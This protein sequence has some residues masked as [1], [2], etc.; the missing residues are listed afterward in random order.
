MARLRYGLG[1]LA[2][3]VCGAAQAADLMALFGEAER[4]DPTY[5]AVKS[6]LEATRELKPQARA[7]AFLPKV[8]IQAE[9][10][11]EFQEITPAADGGGASFGGGEFEFLS[12]GYTLNVTQ[13]VYH[14]DR[15]AQLKQAD[16]RIRASELELDAALQD[17]IVR[18]SERYF[19]VLAAA[20]S[21]EFAQAEKNALARQLE[22]TRERF[23]V[24]LLPITDVEEAQA[25]HDLAVA[26]EIEADNLLDNAH[27]ALR[28]IVGRYHTEFSRLREGIPLLRPAPADIEVWSRKAQEQNLALGRARAEAETARQEIQR[29]TSGHYPTL[30]VVGRHGFNTTGGRFGNVE[31]DASAIG[32]QLTIPVFEG[33]Q[34]NSRTRE[35]GH[36]YTQALQQMEAAQRAAHRQARESYLGVVAGV[37]RVQALKQAVVSTRTAVESTSAGFEVGTRT[38][39]DV[40]AAERALSRARRDYARARYDYVLNGLRLK[41]AAGTLSV[42][43]LKAV[44]GWLVR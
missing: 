35:A 25:G 9:M 10:A 34:V 31:T 24:G 17:L 7:Q 33:G 1:A 26:Q 8:D 40:V 16:S 38:G 42:A 15:Y 27:E 37:S 36:R 44:N 39:V 5:L 41:R 2:I 4:N 13:P 23:G 43:D 22:Q 30:D 32:L 21:L 11:R 18:L 19:D 12:G 20:D 3:W 29:Q 6:G 28:E 14:H